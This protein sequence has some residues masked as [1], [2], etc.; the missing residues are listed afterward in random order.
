VNLLRH[1]EQSNFRFFFVDDHSEDEGR[2]L[3]NPILSPFVQC[4]V[5]AANCSGK[6]AAIHAG[7]Q[8]SSN[9]YILTL[10][11][12]VSV[13]K[14]YFEAVFC[15][16]ENPFELTILPVDLICDP[17]WVGWYQYSEW[18]FLQA[19]TWASFKMNTP[20]LCNGANL[21]FLR[22]LYLDSYA[23]HAHVSSGDD[24]FLLI[25]AVRAKAKINL[26]WGNEF[27]VQTRAKS[28]WY[29]ALNQRLRWAGKTGLLPRSKSDLGFVGFALWQLFKMVVLVSSFWN[30]E[31]IWLSLAAGLVEMAAV[32]L[33]QASSYLFPRILG[34]FVLALT[35]PFIS[36]GIFITSYFIKPEWKGREVS[37]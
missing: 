13:S 4:I 3:L 20:I 33:I 26:K 9:P 5:L 7:I 10:D 22:E 25:H 27:Q 1:W 15:A 32:G 11:A 12:D 30:L 31:Y 36:L 29:D 6:K 35:Y 17:T 21:L 24:L 18:Q 23:T 8:A 2:E 16:T 28:T 14:N 37:L 19:L 34:Q